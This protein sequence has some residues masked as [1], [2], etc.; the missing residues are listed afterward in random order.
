MN[1][2]D[3]KFINTRNLFKFSLEYPHLSLGF[4][5]ILRLRA[6]CKYNTIITIRSGRVSDDCPKF[7]PC[8]GKGEQSFI[9]ECSTFSLC[10]C[11]SLDFIDDLF[12]IFANK[13]RNL[14][15]LP[16]YSNILK[17]ENFINR[18]IYTFLFWNFSFR[19]AT[20]RYWETER[21]KWTTP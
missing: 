12:I 1:Y 18:Y 21:F 20:I 17:Y 11:K 3:F 2:D 15:L 4:N 7:C 10:R 8:C 5:W 14:S 6:G 19:W 16:S 13:V 9:F